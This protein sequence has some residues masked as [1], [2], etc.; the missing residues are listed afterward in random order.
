MTQ[1]SIMK[2][3]ITLISMPFKGRIMVRW[4]PVSTNED[5]R[6]ITGYFIYYKETSE[7]SIGHIDGRDACNE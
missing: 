4:T 7:T 2:D 5:D 1:G 6:K 3:P